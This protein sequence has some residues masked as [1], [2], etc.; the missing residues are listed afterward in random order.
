MNPPFTQPLALEKPIYGGDCLAHLAGKDGKAGKSVFIPLTLPGEI[1][2]AHPI[3]EKRNYIKAELDEVLTPSPSRIPPPCPYFGSCGG[4]HYQHANYPTQLALKEQILR[5]TLH[6]AGVSTSQEIATLTAIPWAY[7]NRIRLAILPDGSFGYRS[8]RSH[9]IVPISECSVAS[10]I[11]LRAAKIT[12]KFL[13]ENANAVPIREM[14]LFTNQNES[15]LLLTLFTAATSTIDPTSWLSALLSALPP[16]TTSIR[17]QQSEGALNPKTLAAIGTP[18]LTYATAG[19]NYQ[20]PHGSFFQ[21]NRYILDDF[22]TLVTGNL[23]GKSA[24]DLYAGAGLFSRHLTQSFAEVHAVEIAPSAYP[25]LQ[26]NLANTTSHAINSTT[27][28]YL[29]LNREN[30]EPRPD[31]I[32]LDPPRAGLGEEVTTLLNAIHAPEMVY[33]SCDPSTLARD[34]RALTQERYTLHSLTLV[35]MFPQTFHLETVA[36][37]RRK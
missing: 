14:E 32:V 1:V 17:I 25:A 37:L 33:V 27:L 36:R 7:R 6:R 4:C 29:H 9:D 8:R 5:E 23:A 10:P 28:D 35:D 12:G 31:L 34:L 20:V 11:L 19:F 18:S 2:N 21:I 15:E 22:T 26:Q 13:A 30:R 16:E 24:W 3:E